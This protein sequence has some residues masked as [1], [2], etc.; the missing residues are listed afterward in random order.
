MLEKTNDAQTIL[1]AGSAL[2]EPVLGHNGIPYTLVPE[3]YSIQSLEHLLPQPA[4][5]KQNALLHDTASFIAYVKQFAEPTTAIFF[6]QAKG[7][8][9]AV[10]DYHGPLTMGEQ[11]PQWCGHTASFAPKAS[12]EWTAWLAADGRR[13]NQTD[14]ATFLEQ[15][16]E[17]IREGKT[18][19]NIA[20]NMQLKREVRFT[21]SQRVQ[22]TAGVELL[23]YQEDVQGTATDGKLAIPASFTLLIQPY[24]GGDASTIECYFRFLLKDGK[25]TLWFELK[26]PLR[27]I[28]NA[29]G[30]IRDYIQE[31][32][33]ITA[34]AGE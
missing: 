4:R 23:N 3:G 20:M 30:I 5:V 16:N 31:G 32:T 18:L 1:D 2:A 21:S 6:N 22:G 27:F 19:L 8:F 29:L 17:D 14:F 26:N 7:S 10:I 12:P 13:M 11:N 33:G 9:R 28:E 34:Y 25:L 15:R 24:I